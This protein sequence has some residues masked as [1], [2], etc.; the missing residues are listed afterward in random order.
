VIQNGCFDIG[1]RCLYAEVSGSGSPTIVLEVGSTQPGTSDAGWHSICAE[2]AKD[3]CVFRYDRANLGRS[4]P[5]PLPRSINAFT[6]DLHALLQAAQVA[7]PYLLL[8]GSFGGM[9]AVNYASLYPHEVCGVVLEDATHPQH[10]LRTL[11]LLP[12]PRP[13]EPPSLSDFRH[14]LWQEYYT[15]LESFE[16][17]G[18]DAPTSIQQANASWNLRDIPLVV[19]TA[20]VNEYEP[21]FP[22]E[23]ARAYENVWM[24]LQK[25]Y[26]TLTTSSTH[27]L[28]EDSDH[29]IHDLRPDIVLEAVRQILRGC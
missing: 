17:E 1:E 18:L 26:T 28:V 21:D 7:P 6:A 13:D 14:L 20:G 24:D 22:P 4:D 19:L 23:I 11:D 27:I 10:D 25:E 15:P 12:P 2:L 16:W 8:G 9:L 3:A 29:V 5:A